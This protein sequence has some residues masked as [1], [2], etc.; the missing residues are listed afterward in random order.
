MA[1]GQVTDKRNEFMLDF[2]WHEPQNVWGDNPAWDQSGATSHLTKTFTYDDEEILTWIKK[3]TKGFRVINRMEYVMVD[4]IEF[5]NEE[6]ALLF[7]LT[8]L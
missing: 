1:V 3:H 2:T 5:I 4:V 8:W 7:K 6:D